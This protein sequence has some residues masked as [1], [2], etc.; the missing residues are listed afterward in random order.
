VRT[1]TSDERSHAAGSASAHAG[2]TTLAATLLGSTVGQK[3]AVAVTGLVLLGFVVLH[4]AGNLKIF[5]GQER[6]DAYARFLREVGYPLLPH[7]GLLWA[8]RVVLVA[9]LALHVTCIVQLARVSR[10]ARA[11]GYHLARDLSFSYA[12]ST[13]RWGGFVLL[14]FVVYHLMHLTWGVAHPGFDHASPYRNV[15][16]AFGVWWVSLPY[17]AA[18]LAL[19]L[20]VQHGLWSTTQT[21]ALRA[22]AGRAVSLVLAAALVVGYLSVPAAVLCGWLRVP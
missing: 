11:R 20:H 10:R 21:L 3:I 16:S 12:S 4:M 22:P 19:G 17:G 15:V 9:A 18:V 14:G 6:F 1:A 2:G 5:Q 8:L 13:M 7:G